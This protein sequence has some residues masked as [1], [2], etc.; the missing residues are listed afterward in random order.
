MKKSFFIFA[1]M[2]PASVMAQDSIL[3][4]Q[5]V[6]TPESAKVFNNE[7]YVS[8]LGNANDAADGFIIKSDLN[9]AN[10]KMLFGAQLDS[11][12]GFA[13]L[14]KNVMIIAD[15]VNDGAKPGNIVIANVATG[16]IL[17]KHSIKNSK[18][19]NDVAA[20]GNGKFALSDS[21]TNSIYILTVSGTQDK[22]STDYT[23]LT[24]KVPGANGLYY[25]EADGSLFAAGSTFG[26][27]TKAGQIYK[28]DLKTGAVSPMTNYLQIGSG[29]LDGLQVYKDKLYVSD[30]GSGKD[31]ASI[32]VL[33]K[34]SNGLY[35]MYDTY[36]NA[37]NGTADFDIYDDYIYLPEM[38]SN[39]IRKVQLGGTSSA[40]TQMPAMQNNIAE[41]GPAQAPKAKSP[42]TGKSTNS[43]AK[44]QIIKK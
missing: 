22:Y 11:P 5:G 26:G 44:K 12:K 8:N 31:S 36:S 3:G 33:Q 42:D 2:F 40:R 17:N 30:W 15:Q 18:F 34:Q 38:T 23:L 32:F 19:L 6:N 7:L 27:D 41:K 20:L 25:N 21:G 29:G 1:L 13:F 28:V 16:K 10:Q 43:A 35:G 14:N 9:G 39:Q 37:F 24:D 4:L